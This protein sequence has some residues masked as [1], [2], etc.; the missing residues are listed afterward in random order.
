MGELEIVGLDTQAKAHLEDAWTLREGEPYNA[1]YAKKF[2][3]ATDRLL[4]PGVS[5]GVS[6][7]EAVNAKDK[8]VDVTIRF[9]PK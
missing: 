1:D 2:L 3:E 4:P 8:T 6:I 9:Q 5:W 7:H